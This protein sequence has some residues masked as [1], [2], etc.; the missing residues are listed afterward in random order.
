MVDSHDGETLKINAHGSVEFTDDETDVQK[1]SPGGYITIE[2]SNGRWLATDS[3]KFDARDKNGTIV[4]TYYSNGKEMS[5]EEGRAWLKTFLPELLREMAVNA[6]RRVGRQLAKGGPGLVLEE[7][8]RTKN[9]YAKSV[10]FREL[11]T[12]A[13]LDPQMLS[14]SL[15][16][17]GRE[18]HSDYDLAE[19]LIAAAKHQA[20]DG[21]LL[22]FVSAS[23]SVKSDYDEGRVLQQAITRPGVT[24]AVA[25]AVFSAAT[26]AAD[27]SGI[28][29][30]YDLA[31]LLSRTPP[32]LIE[33]SASGWAAAIAS[34]GSSYDRSRA[35]EAAL[36][37]G[38]AP[39][40]VQA[41]LDA[42]S[43]IS[44]DYDLATL[45]TNAASAGVL[46]DRTASAYLGAT[47][48]VKS[49]YDRGRVMHEIA[50][51]SL[52]DQSLAQA[53]GLAATMS[54]DYDR[55]EALIAL[56]RAR[57]MGPATKKALSDSA[58]AMHGEYDRGRVLE[59]LSSAG[60]R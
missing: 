50:K 16:Q 20:I 19:T 46:S 41:A 21:A 3:Q 47:S 1:V 48:H 51:S 52:G 31:E 54:S 44:S 25:A 58:S 14:R 56:S 60:V 13:K 9:S 11:F 59:A 49:S 45:L 32:P 29:S 28:Q 34:I 39:A 2:K 36:K 4:R 22:D 33:Q 10:Y 17:A 43:G 37:P 12:Q 55:A 57:G 27:N 7:I 38:A 26:P 35:I 40:T 18:V 42:A 6:D 30:D 23:R 15:Q 8:G 5:A 53:V 24:P